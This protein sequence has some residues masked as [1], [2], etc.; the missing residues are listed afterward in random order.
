LKIARHT[1][2]KLR[3]VIAQL[4][5]LLLSD[6]PHKST[7]DGLSL[8]SEF[9]RKS[10]KLVERAE[11]SGVPALLSSAC[12]T[13]NERIVNYLPVMGFLLRST[14][15]RNNFECFDVLAE[16]ATAIIGPQSKVVIS[17]EW[18]F[19]PLTYPLSVSV[20]PNF[21]LIGM[22]A[23]ESDNA[24]ILPLAGHELGHSAWVN[25]NFENKYAATVQTRAKD[26][27]K[28]NVVAFKLAYP[29]HN[30]LNITEEELLGNIFLAHIITDIKALALSHIEEI[31]CDGVGL[32][33]FGKSFA[34]AFHYL[35]APGVGGM[36]SPNY[37]QLSTRARFMTTYG[38]VDFIAIGLADFERDFLINTAQLQAKSEF[39]LRAA[40]YIT[41]DLASTMYTEA[42]DLIGRKARTMLPDPSSEAEILKMF[43]AGI[44]AKSPGSL[45]N[46]INAGWEFVLTEKSSRSTQHRPVFE[47]IS[48][49]MFKTIEVF[50]YE[51]RVNAK[52]RRTG[53]KNQNRQYW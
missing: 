36:R 5:Q 9:F 4:D 45:A 1:R 32:T 29:E 48:E 51:R 27:I 34:Y 12:V 50:E 30:T 49:L 28:T 14:N 26:F 39:I 19:S 15:V 38:N 35:L 8:L 2:E 21:L 18:D 22:P 43:H 46:I 10:D 6:M 44:P 13:A 41:N 24:L 7:E 52:L 37:P 47:W 23:P 33:L 25:E 53:R 3:A 20:L 16:L 17:S 42:V 11:A 40:D 31:F